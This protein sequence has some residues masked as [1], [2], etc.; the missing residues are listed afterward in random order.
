MRSPFPH[1]TPGGQPH[2]RVRFHVTLEGA[3]GLDV[4]YVR[5]RLERWLDRARLGLRVAGC[6][7]GDE[8]RLDPVTPPAGAGPMPGGA[9]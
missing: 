2:R 4:A 1:E 9:A 6:V 3:P 7:S 8:T 5:D